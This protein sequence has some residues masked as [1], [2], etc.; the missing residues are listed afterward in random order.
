MTEQSA[1]SVTETAT[2]PPDHAGPRR[3]T[4]QIVLLIAGFALAVGL[5]YVIGYEQYASRPT[6]VVTPPP[7]RP[8]PITSA[9][10]GDI[11]VN[12]VVEN[13][14][15]TNF[16][17]RESTRTRPLVAV[18]LGSAPVC[19]SVAVNVTDIQNG[20]HVDVRGTRTASGV[21]AS[22]VTISRVPGG[23]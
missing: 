3:S 4:G 8:C 6:K 2:G 5:G 15:D 17:V 16:T 14:S 7:G 22:Q 21:D 18:N 19:R 20:D 10:P 1:T 13:R 23:G 12:G 11:R 9:A